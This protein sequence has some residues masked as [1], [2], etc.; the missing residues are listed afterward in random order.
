MHAQ[1][2]RDTSKREEGSPERILPLLF[3]CQSTDYQY[4][5]IFI[6]YLYSTV[7]AL[8]QIPVGICPAC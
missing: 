1:E 8:G 4:K 3:H 2:K 7:H 6:R 5:L